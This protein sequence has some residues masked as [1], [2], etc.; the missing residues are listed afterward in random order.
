VDIKDGKITCKLNGKKITK[1]ILGRK[2]VKVGD[3]EEDRVHVLFDVKFAGKEYED[4]EFTLD[5]RSNRVYPVLV[6]RQFL[7]DNRF[8]VN[9]SK[10]FMMVESLTEKAPP[11]ADMERFIKN[12]KQ[13]FID[14]YGK[15]KG[16]EIL[17]ATA[18]KMFNKKQNEAFNSVLGSL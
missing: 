11:D 15:E 2:N 3:E 6:G 7:T 1:K 17:Y 14:R 13:D 4:V 12:Q 9:P 8:T 5:N 18:W 10:K 16:M